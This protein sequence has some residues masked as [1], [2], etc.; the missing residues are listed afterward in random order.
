MFR[1]I[2][3][4]SP[5]TADAA[6]RAKTAGF[7]FVGRYLVPDRYAKALTRPE[8]EAI[9][10][11]GLRILTVWETTAERAAAGYD[12]GA[13]DGFNAKACARAIGMPEDGIIYFAV[14]FG[15]GAIHMPAIAQYISAACVNVAPYWAGVY[16]S[17]DVIEA[18]AQHESCRG[19]WQCVGWSGGKKS[20]HRTVYQSDWS[21]TAAAK[22]AAAK[23]GVSVDLNECED[24]DR[25]GIWTYSAVG[26]G[27]RPAEKPAEGNEKGEDMIITSEIVEDI[28]DVLT[29]RQA[30]DI[31][32]KAQ[33]HAATLGLPEWAT[34]ERKEAREYAE[35]KRIGITDGTRPMGLVTRLEA[36]LMAYRGGGASEE[37]DGK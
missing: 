30:Y 24:M 14:D 23:I 17:Y 11:A 27:E 28:L 18:M 29:P 3:C 5:L 19:F 20:Q 16:G 10:E 31:L 25:A 26:E 21:G 13:F 9:T 2:D 8:A 12:A 4:A 22:A 33:D 15:A 6:Q 35:A 36:A 37:N 32:R 7:D 34:G 1:G